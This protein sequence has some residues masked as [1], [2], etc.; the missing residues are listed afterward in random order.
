MTA[1][2][3]ELEEFA[4]KVDPYKF[5]HLVP[6]MGDDQNKAGEAGTGGA[7]AGQDEPEDED[8]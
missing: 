1:G 6:G 7:E 4:R 2:A 5:T 3:Q 8:G